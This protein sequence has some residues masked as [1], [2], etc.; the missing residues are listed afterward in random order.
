MADEYSV[1]AHDAGYK[2]NVVNKAGTVCGTFDHP[3]EADA[4][5]QLLNNG[6]LKE[7][8]LTYLSPKE[9]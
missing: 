9:D 3:N 5:C 4:H 7:S 8:D 6:I 2:H 1:E